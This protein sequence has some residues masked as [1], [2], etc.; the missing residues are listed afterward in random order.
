[1][2][3]SRADCV[4]VFNKEGVFLYNIGSSGSGDGRFRF[5]A[6]LTVD[7]F[8]RLIVCDYDNNRLPVFTLDGKFVTKIRPQRTGFGWPW[9]VAVSNDGR[10]L[11]TDVEEHCVYYVFQ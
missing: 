5:P 2:S 1:M 10:L 9:S 6:G 3:Y 8:G 11:V 4:K 7:T